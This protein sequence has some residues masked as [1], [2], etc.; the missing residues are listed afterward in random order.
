MTDEDRTILREITG[1]NAGGPSADMPK[2][3][4]DRFVLEHKIG[5]G[6]MGTVYRAKDLRRVEAH[7][8]HPYVAVKVLNQE[9]RDHRDAFVALERES[10]KS[11]GL[12]HPNIVSIFDFDK[13]GD[14]PFMTME[15]LEGEELADFLRRYPSGVPGD[16][17]WSL[18][19]GM[20]RGLAHAHE[21]GV[22]HADFKPGNVFVNGDTAKI[23]DFGIARAVHKHR[24]VD[25]TFD[26]STLAALTPAYASREMLIGDA[27]DP[28][29]DVYSLAV[30]IY[31]TLT[32]R[33]PYDRERADKA[34]EYGMVPE[35]P[36][37]L[38]HRQWRALAAGL[39]FDR[40]KRPANAAV[41]CDMLFHGPIYS[42]RVFAASIS[43][44]AVLATVAFWMSDATRTE[45]V[46]E[47]LADA[48][49]IRVA[50]LISEPSLDEQW[51]EQ[52]IQ[53]LD[54]LAEVDETGTLS[55][56]ARTKVTERYADAIEEADYNRGIK[57]LQRA[58]RFGD[59][60]ELDDAQLRLEAVAGERVEKL[61]AGD[62][63]RAQ[64]D[65]LEREMRR[66][67]S[68][69]GETST[70]QTIVNGLNDYYLAELEA[71][72][73]IDFAQEIVNALAAREFDVDLLAYAQ[74]RA[75]IATEV[76][77][78]SKQRQQLDERR[79][80][81]DSRLTGLQEDLSC[82]RLNVDSVRTDTEALTGEFPEFS[83]EVTL[84]VEARLADCV[85]E[86]ARTDREGARSLQSDAIRWLGP[87]RNLTRIRIDP[88]AMDYLVGNGKTNGRGGF[89][90]D[91][92]ADDRSG[93][94]LVVIPEE[95]AEQ[96]RYAI[97]KFEIAWEHYETYC[98]ETRQ[99]EPTD[100]NPEPV[101][102]IRADEAIAYAH[103]LSK[104]TGYQYRL[105]TRDE[106]DRAARG[107]DGGV[108]PNRNCRVSVGGI[109]RGLDV[110][111][112]SSG[113]PN[114]Y[115]V[116]NHLG[117]VQEWVVEGDSLLA[118]GGAFTDPLATCG[119]EL[120]RAHDG[121]ADAIT[122]FRLVRELQ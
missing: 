107:P 115:G 80:S 71:A 34:A 99:C 7:N 27:P 74:D 3:L 45:V 70:L 14:V 89:C 61:K 59:S 78:L 111:A 68:V 63:D 36:R 109:E 39:T 94:R 103:W 72:D 26:V 43:A 31:L 122:G 118:V 91:R 88:C 77:A 114:G 8:R 102:G 97:T 79:E 85:T 96:A 76:E 1:G 42:N 35:R 2:I 28:S 13:D 40:D 81:F 49:M 56:A 50:D 20:C 58:R 57:L 16:I 62:L 22:V 93:P 21:A 66:F 95:G 15:L 86:V 73:G 117:N 30:V 82:F 23:L 113:Q 33:H 120:A 67:T 104:Q 11:Q 51:H 55:E 108:D 37:G 98:L 5:A 100:G 119:F 9:F 25:D 121:D 38:S 75:V 90:V 4:K 17:A 46:E 32:G 54:R 65:A 110:V 41:L 10:S 60:V 52:V 18:I 84:V 69:F 83:R 48:Q 116:V 44:V 24:D 29:D 64:F 53:E 87:R 101:T 112:S 6:G 105:P 106:W 12:S 19:E 92:V 47:A